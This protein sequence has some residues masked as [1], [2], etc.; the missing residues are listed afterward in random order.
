MASSNVEAYPEDFKFFRGLNTDKELLD[1][2]QKMIDFLIQKLNYVDMDC[3]QITPRDLRNK[4]LYRETH[5]CVLPRVMMS[6]NYCRMP[7]SSPSFAPSVPPA[8]QGE[9]Q[10]D[11]NSYTKDQLI[12][13]AAQMGVE[14]NGKTKGKL[15][16]AIQR[17]SIP[18]N[19]GNT[20]NVDGYCVNPNSNTL[21]TTPQ[22]RQWAIDRKY[23]GANSS[24][25]Q[26][27]L[28]QVEKIGDCTYPLRFDK[29]K[30]SCVPMGSPK[31][32]RGPRSPKR[33]LKD[34]RAQA[35]GL[36]VP[37][38]KDMTRESLNRNIKTY[39][40]CPTAGMR[41]LGANGV[42]RESYR[43]QLVNRMAPLMDS[44]YE[45]LAAISSKKMSPT[46]A[47]KVALSMSAIE[48]AQIQNELKG[49]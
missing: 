45:T 46:D 39:T 31:G 43:K 26:C 42:C 4:I 12:L 34:L 14:S 11:L 19:D 37:H 32:P 10:V 17:K 30:G 7:R 1:N 9:Q 13:I 29:V 41:V 44:V 3:S 20:R 24:S 38:T 15:M 2:R 28:N 6:D 48:I 36:G 33:T 47:V 22:L 49:M 5:R 16:R 18:C 40:K 35:A 8:K 25:R 21:Y 27:L 23:P